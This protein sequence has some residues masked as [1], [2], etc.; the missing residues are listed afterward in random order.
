[1]RGARPVPRAIRFRNN[2]PP[3]AVRAAL[4]SVAPGHCHAAGATRSGAS[5]TCGVAAACKLA[6]MRASEERG[7]HA[8]RQAPAA[9]QALST[10]T[11]RTCQRARRC[12]C[13]PHLLALN[14]AAVLVWEWIPALPGAP[15]KKGYRLGSGFSGAHRRKNSLPSR[16]SPWPPPMSCGVGE[17][18]RERDLDSSLLPARSQWLV[19]LM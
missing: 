1:M 10:A 3:R 12:L 17:T 19:R 6:C 11:E 7:H 5:R 14:R 8:R 2:I 4:R 9:G 18:E 13:Y 15:I 16:R